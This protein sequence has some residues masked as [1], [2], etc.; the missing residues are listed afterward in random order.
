[1]A[2]IDGTV[3]GNLSMVQ[4]NAG[5]H[6]RRFTDIRLIW[7]HAP[8]IAQAALPGQFVMVKCDDLT[9]PRPISIHQVD[10]ESIAL[11]FSVL[12][13]GKGTMWLSKLEEG[14]TVQLLGP[15]GNGF[16]VNS[17]SARLLLI[18]GGMGI[19]PLFFWRSPTTPKGRQSRC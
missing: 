18:S 9:L 16:T 15:L 3:T 14:Q 12:A 8:E 13:E 7:L 11:F 10:G 17:A 5:D 2:L 19:A 4:G 1:M 6:D